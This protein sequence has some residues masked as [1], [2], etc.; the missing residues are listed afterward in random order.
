MKFMTMLRKFMALTCWILAGLW[1]LN[2]LWTWESDNCSFNLSISDLAQMDTG[3]KLYDDHN[4]D[5]WDSTIA[6][7]CQTKSVK[8]TTF[9]KVDLNSECERPLK[10]STDCLSLKAKVTRSQNDF[11]W[12]KSLSGPFIVFSMACHAFKIIWSEFVSESSALN[13]AYLRVN[14][15]GQRT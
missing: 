5:K 14:V 1:P 10:T 3:I 12:V 4:D 13:T 15:W 7:F 9:D 2:F 11:F 6:F 8:S